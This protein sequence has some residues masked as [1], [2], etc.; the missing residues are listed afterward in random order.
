VFPLYRDGAAPDD[1]ATAATAIF[2]LRNMTLSVAE[3][4]NPAA[5]ETH[6]RVFQMD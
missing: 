3:R 2:D 6:V 1:S 5:R 4:G